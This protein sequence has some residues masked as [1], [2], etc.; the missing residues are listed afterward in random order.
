M[1]ETARS[2]V[3]AAVEQ[4]TSEF[5]ETVAARLPLSVIC[6]LMGV[7]REDW[8]LMYSLTSTA[9]GT[10]DAAEQSVAHQEILF[11]YVDLAE[12]R[13]RDPRDD[14]VSTLVTGDV[15]GV[16]LTNEEIL[17][18][19][20]N[21]MVAGTETVRYATAGGMLAFIEHPDQWKR[22]ETERGLLETAV[23][24]I[25]RWSSPPLHILRTATSHV[26]IGG[27]AI[28]PGQA[29]TVWTP[30]VNRDEEAFD[31][32]DD[33]DVGREGNRH[34]TLGAGEHFCLGAAL[35]RLE[36][37]VL[38]EELLDQVLQVELAGPVQRVR[39][40]ITFGVER[41]PVALTATPGPT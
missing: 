19:C 3:A 10:A 21:L 15:D 40:L 18:N 2:L 39:S 14:L 23:E 27:Q 32:P 5:V 12:Q 13:R 11:Y 7:P 30:S 35:A 34:L 28:L 8:E 4:G 17:L 37:R 26:E 29:V 31:A 36:L 22:L 9:F 25:L 16:S 6:D 33:F 24:E 38:F 41:M 1:R 20:D